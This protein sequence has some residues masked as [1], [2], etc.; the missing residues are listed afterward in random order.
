MPLG[1]FGTAI[2]LIVVAVALPAIYALVW[3]GGVARLGVFLSITTLV[4]VVVAVAAFNWQIAP[5]KNIGIAG[6]APGAA[7]SSASFEARLMWRFVVAIV[8]L[9]GIQAVLS[10][11]L[12]NLLRP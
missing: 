8:S 1:F 7:D 2:C 4:G 3:P 11:V 5:L 6:V 9:V 10:A 12:R